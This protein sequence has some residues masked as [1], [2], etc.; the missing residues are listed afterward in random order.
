MKSF[1]SRFALWVLSLFMMV[2]C[3]SSQAFVKGIYITQGTLE[4][5]KLITYLIQRAKSVGIST[6]IVDLELPG[7]RYQKNIR[8]LQDNNIR[9]VARIIM[10]PDGGKPAQILTES[11]WQ[12]KYGLV[13]TALGYGAAEIQLD[14]IR[15]SSK[16]PASS[17][18]S[19]HIHRIIRWYKDRLTADKIPLQ[20]DVFG[21]SSFGE[22]KHIGQN[23]KLFS[24][25][26][27]AICPMVYPSHYE[28]FR[29][30]A[31]TP[32]QTVYKSLAMIKA[33]FNTQLSFKLIPYIELS[34]YRYPLSQPKKIEYIYAQIRAAQ[35]AGADGWYAWSPHNQYDN[36]FAVLQ[37]YQVK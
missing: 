28:P 29:V 31:V 12:R 20:V 17:E 10:F 30:H 19:K 7:K 5:T 2:F 6:F 21:I 3:S 25:T 9:Y 33:M 35:D 15:Y 22:E 1:R 34:N 14:Y 32:Y 16:Q 36:L 4:N 18:N 13:Q 8:L 26:V 37:R 23:I 24:Q 11:Y 27:D